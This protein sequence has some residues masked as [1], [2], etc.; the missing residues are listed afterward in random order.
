[1]HLALLV[2]SSQPPPVAFM[3][4]TMIPAE[5]N[6]FIHDKELLAIVR[7]LEE[8]EPELLSLQEPFV[9]ATDHR[10]LEYF[11][12][13]LK[14][15]ARQARWAEYLSRFNF[16]ITYPPGYENRAADALS[17][18]IPSTDHDEV[19][20]VTLLPCELFMSEALADLDAVVVAAGGDERDDGDDEEEDVDDDEG[21]DP[22]LELEAANRADTEEMTKLRELAQGV[23]P[24]YS[25]DSRVLLRISDKVYLPED[26]PTLAGLLIRH[27]HEQPSTGHPGRNRMVRLLS[28]RFHLKNL[29]Q[30]VAKYLKNCPVCCKLW[31]HT[32]PPPLLR[33]L[34]VPDSPW[35]DVSVDYVGPLPTS[36]GFNMLMVV[37]DR[38]TKMRHYI[39]CTAK[40][41]DS[42]TS[43]P[44]MARLFLNHVFPLHGLLDTIVSDRG[45]QFISAFWE[46]LMSPLGFKRKLTTVYHPQTDGQTEW[47]NQDLENYLRRYVSWKQDDWA[48]WLSVA[49]FAAN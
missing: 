23:S 35:R 22:I 47:V 3:S 29:A 45:S 13:K 1:M 33:P 4:K 36:D 25:V 32:I 44:A 19:C 48:P 11:M 18:R 43:A 9:V 26:T 16:K 49:E 21:R 14:L 17:R 42:G 27:V 28:A 34:P 41:A 37:V 5:L 24:G 6:Y 31:R 2:G 46:H 8:W 30:R 38:L 12:T 15:N 40:E 7:A 10:A 39:P 20:N